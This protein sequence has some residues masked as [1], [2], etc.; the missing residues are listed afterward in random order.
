MSLCVYKH[1]DT[2]PQS[3]ER[4]LLMVEVINKENVLNEDAALL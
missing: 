4:V 3:C 1:R 2:L